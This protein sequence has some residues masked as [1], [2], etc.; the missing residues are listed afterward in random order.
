MMRLI[1]IAAL[2]TG[3]AFVFAGV[4]VIMSVSTERAAHFTPENAR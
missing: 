1:L 2:A 3:I 4:T